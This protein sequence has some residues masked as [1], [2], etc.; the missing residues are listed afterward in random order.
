MTIKEQIIK[1][2]EDCKDEKKLETIWHFILQ[3]LH[4]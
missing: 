2:I 1:S 4:R 3:Y